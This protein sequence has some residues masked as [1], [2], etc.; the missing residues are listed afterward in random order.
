MYDWVGLQQAQLPQL[1]ENHKPV[2][3]T[4][5]QTSN[6]STWNCSALPGDGRLAPRREYFS[7]SC[8]GARLWLVFLTARAWPAHLFT[9]FLPSVIPSLWLRLCPPMSMLLVSCHHPIYLAAY[10][11]SAPSAGLFLFPSNFGSLPAELL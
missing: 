7:G 2:M 8:H 6:R 9:V 4:L 1:Q 10:H 5:E 3:Q 11:M